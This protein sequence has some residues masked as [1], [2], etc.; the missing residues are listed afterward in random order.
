[1]NTDATSL[2][3]VRADN[4]LVVV[5]MWTFGCFNCK[6]TI[7]ALQDI[8]AE[9]GDRI[10]IVG[11][12]APE[13]SF[14]ADVDNIIEAAADLG[15]DWPIA[16]DTDKRNFHRWQEGPTAWWPTVYLIDGDNQ[17]RMQQSGDGTHHYVR[18]ADYIERLLAGEE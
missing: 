16:L 14:E 4:E 8:R 1:M 17:I 3:E 12:H 5:Q 15:V 6:N 7:E 9:F 11:V 10:E 18:L 13:F 2:E